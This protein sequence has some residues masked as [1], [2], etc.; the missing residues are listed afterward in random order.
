[1]TPLKSTELSH[2]ET[3]RSS[4]GIK[5]SVTCMQPQQIQWRCKHI[6]DGKT[7]LVAMYQDAGGTICN[8]FPV[9]WQMFTAVREQRKT[10]TVISHLGSSLRQNYVCYFGSCFQFADV[11]CHSEV[12]CYFW[13]E[14]EKPPKPPNLHDARTYWFQD[15]NEGTPR[16]YTVYASSV[17]GLDECYL[18]SVFPLNTIVF[19]L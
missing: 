7:W 1:M 2:G 13:K 4:A 14:K 17:Y 8:G 9:T 3:Q 18:L 19:V 12:C 10:H 16:F 11:I 15:K 6:H 5:L